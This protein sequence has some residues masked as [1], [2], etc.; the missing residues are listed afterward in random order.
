MIEIALRRTFSQ[1]VASLRVTTGEQG[2]TDR[3]WQG[4]S[5]DVRRALVVGWV[6]HFRRW[7]TA[8]AGSCGTKCNKFSDPSAAGFLADGP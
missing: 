2:N 8:P 6:G 4:K 5:A 3:G 7:A 1:V